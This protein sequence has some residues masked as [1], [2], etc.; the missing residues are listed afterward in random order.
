MKKNIKNYILIIVFVL[1]IG[2]YGLLVGFTHRN[3]NTEREK[4]ELSKLPKFTI[5]NYEAYSGQFTAFLKDYIPFRQNITTFYNNLSINVFE[6]TTDKGVILGKDN[7]LFYN[8]HEKDPQTDEL[9]DYSGSAL[10]TEAQMERIAAEVRAADEFCAAHGAKMIFLIAPNKSTV[11]SQYMPDLYVRQSDTSRIDK[12]FEYLCENTDA[13]IMYPE[14]ELIE[15]S[16]TN[17]T[18]FANDTHW[19]GLGGFLTTT[20]LAEEFSIDYP[21]LDEVNLIE[22]SS[23]EDLKLMLGVDSYP[24]DT[25][26]TIPNYAEIYQSTLVASSENMDSYVSDNPNGKTMLLLGDS[27]SEKLVPALGI[28]VTNLDAS[29][30]RSYQ[31]TEA[32]QYDYVVYEMV[33]RNIAFLAQ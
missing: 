14:K 11:Y 9:I 19:N 27:F 1:F 10:Y 17:K 25:G 2:Y 16:K 13:A 24:A 18:F 8:S 20:L 33:E 5:E 21:S 26:N 28:A 30:T 15:Y 12:L 22:D 7:W 6:K 3:A 23:P 32:K 4:R 29:R 31:F